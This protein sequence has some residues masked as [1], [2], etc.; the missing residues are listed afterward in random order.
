MLMVQQIGQTKR[1]T[2]GRA[3]RRVSAELTVTGRV[4]A[5]L[6]VKSAIITAGDIARK[7][8][9]G[10]IRRA[11][12]KRGSTTKNCRRLPERTTARY[13]PSE[14]MSS[15]ARTWAASWAANA[16]MPSGSVQ[17]RPRII[18]K[19]SSC[20][21]KT[22]FSSADFS[23]ESF[24]A[25]MPNPAAAATSRIERTLPARNGWT[26]LFGITFRTWS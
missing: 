17:T 5:E 6:L 16:T 8:R 1:A 22:P 7:T 4:A 14:P 21:P 2:S 10:S 26:I 19:S 11:S 20:R 25:A 23:G 12:R 24:I 18:V 13:L 3:P 9:S 15:P